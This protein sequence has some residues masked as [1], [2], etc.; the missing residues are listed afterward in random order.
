MPARD[1]PYEVQPGREL[2]QQRRREQL[3]VLVGGGRR[4]CDQPPVQPGRDRR[5][6]GVVEHP[7]AEGPEQRRH[8]G[9]RRQAVPLHVGDQRPHPVRSRPY[10]VQVA[11]DQGAVLRRPVEAGAAHRT[12]LFRQRREDRQLSRLRHRPHADQLRV[13]ALPDPGDHHAQQP[14]DGHRGQVRPPRVADTEGGRSQQ[15]EDERGEER[16]PARPVREGGH[17][18]QTGQEEPELDVARGEHLR[19]DQPHQGRRGRDP[20]PARRRLPVQPARF[21]ASASHTSTLVRGRARA[22]GPAAGWPCRS[23][24]ATVVA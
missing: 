14:D 19:E 9:D 21:L 20:G 12:H 13:P 16:G 24:A 17:R 4:V 3:G 22:P 1:E 8:R 10:V 7:L 15:Y 5:Q 11:A 6:P 23:P 2:Q 18:W